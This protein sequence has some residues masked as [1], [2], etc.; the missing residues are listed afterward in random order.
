MDFENILYKKEDGVGIVTINSPKSL[1]A[2]NSKILK[3]LNGL[4]DIIENDKD[5]KVLIITGQGKAFVAGADI[6][7]LKDSSPEKGR[8]FSA[9]GND[10]FRRIEIMEKPVIAAINGLAFGGGCELAMSCD[11]RI[12]GAKAKLCQ[13]EVGLGIIPGFGGTQ[14]L[15]RLVGVAKAKELIYSGNI[16]TA[17]EAEKIGLVNKV[18]PQEELMDTTMTL[19]NKI[20][21]VSPSAVKYAKLA[22]NSGI[23]SDIETG[24]TTE[25][26]LLGLC[27][28]TYDQKEGISAFIEKRKANFKGE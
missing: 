23:E 3:E 17:I 7:E 6:Y 18:V 19:A 13:P 16:I 14:R 20:A 24:I 9:L 8:K 10:V 27:F 4:I 12:A 5:I 1:N 21:S 15:P 25:K 26:N 28:A 11:I 22:I 2:L